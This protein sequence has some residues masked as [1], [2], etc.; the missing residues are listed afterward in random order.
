MTLI[1]VHCG[2]TKSAVQKRLLAEKDLTLEKGASFAQSVEI[3]EKGSKDLQTSATPKPATTLDADLFKLNPKNQRGKGAKCNCC[4]GK[5][6]ASQVL[7]QGGAMSQLWQVWA[8]TYIVKQD[9]T[10]RILGIIRGRKVSRITLAYVVREK[11][12]AIISICAVAHLFAQG[13]SM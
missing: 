10:Y 1:T 11:T 6:F 9:G 4:G 13:I 2:I 3:T 5:Y 7:I 8:H 12:F